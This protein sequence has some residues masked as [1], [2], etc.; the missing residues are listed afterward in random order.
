MMKSILMVLLLSAPGCF[1]TE[2][3]PNPVPVET[4]DPAPQA[5][6]CTIYLDGDGNCVQHSDRSVELCGPDTDDVGKL[7]KTES[8]ALQFMQCND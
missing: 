8:Q 7:C 6:C 2:S 1:S 5:P 3:E 4:S